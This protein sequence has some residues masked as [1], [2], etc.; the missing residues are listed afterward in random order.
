MRMPY[1]IGNAANNVTPVMI[2][3][4]SLPSHVGVMESTIWS[5]DFSFGC[6]SSSA[7]TPRSNPSSKTY[8]A[9]D[10][11]ANPAQKRGKSIVLPPHQGI[12]VRAIEHIGTECVLERPRGVSLGERQIRPSPNDAHHKEKKCGHEEC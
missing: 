4:V 2:S 1:A 9:T 7:P 8:N 5:L 3:H 10:R 6:N 12:G 11:A